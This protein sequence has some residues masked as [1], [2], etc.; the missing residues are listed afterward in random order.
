[1]YKIF[2]IVS[3]S[4]KSISDAIANQH[5]N[6]KPNSSKSLIEKKNM[7]QHTEP[8]KKYLNQKERGKFVLSSIDETVFIFY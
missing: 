6:T 4:T 8:C 2:F 1:M 3:D 7:V 5:L